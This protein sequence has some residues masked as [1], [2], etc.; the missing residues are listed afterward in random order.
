VVNDEK[1]TSKHFK[2]ELT[3]QKKIFKI[4][5]ANELKLEELVWL[6]NRVLDEIIKN[7]LFAQEINRNNITIDDKTLNDALK[8]A[9]DGYEENAFIK[10]LELE[11]F[12]VKEWEE[13]V[14]INLLINKLIQNLVNSKVVIGNKELRDYFDKNIIKFHKKEKV[15]ALHIM[16]GTEDEIRQIQKELKSK[17]KKFEELAKEFSLGPEGPEGGDLGYFEPGQM[18]EEF[19]DVF[20]LKK[21][22]TS[23]IIKTPYG[24]HLLKVVDKIQERKMTFDESKNMIR[25]ILTQDLRDKGFQNWFIK[26]KNKS[27]I[28]V[29][30]ELLQKIY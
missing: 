3:K 2:N 1:I 25:K 24:F 14:K 16:V 10:A 9:K 30:Y 27:R 21:N 7:T 19:D 26:L 11:G 13:K 5:N 17:Q 22:K 15:R 29:N 6:K 23:D 28:E 12:S 4:K 20:K 18:P 8:K